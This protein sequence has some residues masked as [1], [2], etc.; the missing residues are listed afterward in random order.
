M[1]GTQTFDVIVVGSGMSG[2]WAA[3]E[4]T[5]R[6]MKTL[7]VERGKKTERG[8]D[9]LGENKEPWDMPMRD[10]VAPELADQD[11]PVQSQCYAFR[12]STRNFFINDR[13][14]PYS[15]EDDAPFMW[16]RGDQVGG[17]SL[18][19]ARQSYRWSDLDFGAN[20]ADGHGCD[21]PI[22]YADIEDN[23]PN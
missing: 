20:K 9:Y 12:E 15:T 3:K 7:V 4:F 1:S 8:V 2:G 21:W 16:V 22:R 19:W 17:K 10:R 13:E 18:M 5:E 11:Y 14:N 23:V 6:G